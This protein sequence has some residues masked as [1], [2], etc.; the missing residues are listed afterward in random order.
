MS[1]NA[2]RAEP[3][4]KPGSASERRLHA[5]SAP[6]RR[7]RPRLAYALLAVTGVAVIGIVQM[8]LSLASTQDS[9]VLAD[10]NAK[11]RALSLEKQAMQDELVGLSSP[12]SLASKAASLGLV[13]AG[14]ASYLRLSDGAILGVADE[15]GWTSTVNP[16]GPTKVGNAL[17]DAPK[18]E[19]PAARGGAA[20][21]AA[22][23]DAAEKKTDPALPPS[24]DDGLPIPQTH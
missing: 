14:S 6:G 10:L 1:L 9:F 11:Q 24:L 21:E 13:V 18:P 7:R 2:L 19:K 17:L 22:E 23:T 20:S 15:P 4:E 5:L 16:N 8:G 12:Q 3:R